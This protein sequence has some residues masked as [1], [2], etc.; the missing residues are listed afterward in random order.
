[1]GLMLRYIHRGEASRR[2]GVV[3]ESQVVS[4]IFLFS[5]ENELSIDT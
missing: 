1:M 3:S 2:K 5:F 4:F